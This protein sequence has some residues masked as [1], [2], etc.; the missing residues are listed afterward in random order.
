MMSLSNYELIEAKRNLINAKSRSSSITSID[1]GGTR[2]PKFGL[3]S[4][5]LTVDTLESQTRRSSIASSVTSS[6]TGRLKWI[7]IDGVWKRV[8][9]QQKDD[10]EG[11]DQDG[12]NTNETGSCVSITGSE[13]TDE[14][15]EERYRNQSEKHLSRMVG[16]FSDVP[17]II[18]VSADILCKHVGEISNCTVLLT[19]WI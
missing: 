5:K 16:T 10:F 11:E 3:K 13:Q 12:T 18:I 8:M 1:R 7:D 19:N 2:S 15:L 9:L 17:K 6:S 14:P 4:I